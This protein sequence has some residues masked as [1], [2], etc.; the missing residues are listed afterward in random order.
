MARPRNDYERTAHGLTRSIDARLAAGDAFPVVLS[1]MT[2]FGYGGPLPHHQ[3][4]P[5]ISLTVQD[6][7]FT[8]TRQHKFGRVVWAVDERPADVEELVGRLVAEAQRQLGR[9]VTT[10]EA[11]E[12][13]L[14]ALRGETAAAAA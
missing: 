11:V 8:A 13:A 2:V 14:V 9:E 10:A 3:P 4:G 1:G 12:L 6:R 7:V 5:T